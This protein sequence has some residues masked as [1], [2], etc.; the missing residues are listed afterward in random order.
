[1]FTLINIHE[2]ESFIYDLLNFNEFNNFYHKGIVNKC[3]KTKYK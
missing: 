3:M 2:I 1:M